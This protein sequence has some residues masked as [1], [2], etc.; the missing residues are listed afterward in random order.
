MRSLLAIV[1][2]IL[3]VFGIAV[4]GYK[5]FTYT[6]QEKVAEIGSVKVTADTE[7]QIYFHPITGGLAIIGGIVLLVAARRK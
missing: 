1:G 6:S 3:I 4:L 2:I 5:G 7:K